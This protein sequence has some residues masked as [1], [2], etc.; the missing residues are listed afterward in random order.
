MRIFYINLDH[1]TGR[2]DHTEAQLSA[3][4]LTAERIAAT[5]PADLPQ[6][7]LDQA[8]NPNQRRFVSPGELACT[9]SHRNAWE[10]IVN[11]RLPMALIL[12]DDVYLSKRLPRLLDVV[13]P[14]GATLDIIR[15]E[16]QYDNIRLGPPTYRDDGIALRPIHSVVWGCGGYIVTQAGAAKLLG[17][18][19]RFNAPVDAIIFDYHFGLSKQLRTRQAVPAGIA[20][21]SAAVT[22]QGSLFASTLEPSRSQRRLHEPTGLKR[23]SAQA[24]LRW[25]GKWSGFRDN[26]RNWI[27]RVLRGIEIVEVPL[28]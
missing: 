20:N 6:Q 12:E 3:L 13:E 4:G 24:T 28:L 19:S 15:L 5:V 11:E 14:F 21:G 8:C 7:L 17:P 23:I 1:E 9:M 26:I 16:T 18:L 2:R 25:G 22:I 27:N 10:R